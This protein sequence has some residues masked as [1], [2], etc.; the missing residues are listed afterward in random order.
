MAIVDFTKRFSP[1]EATRG[2]FV[3][4]DSS[5]LVS[6]TTGDSTGLA[7]GRYAELTY[8]IGSEPGALNISLSGGT[9][10]LPVSTVN[11]NEPL[12]VENE[13]GDRLDVTIQEPLSTIRVFV[14]T[15][16]YNPLMMA[17]TSVSAV[18]FAN[19]VTLLEVFNND[20]TLPIYVGFNS[21]AIE[22][23]S[24]QGLPI[25]AESFYSIDR[26]TSTVYI[27]NAD[28]LLSVDVR[29]VGHYKA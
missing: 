8:I 6:Y 13:P 26:D 16:V 27:G 10:I 28:P 3:P 29:V 20:N 12:R 14:D 4:I 18:N 25:V 15:T 22:T 23:L 19:N 11:I 9:V 21:V 17:P 1:S 7:R 5:S 2:Q 24:A